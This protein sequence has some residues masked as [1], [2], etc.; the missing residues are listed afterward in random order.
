MDFELVD[1]VT[2][3]VRAL[4]NHNYAEFSVMCQ[5]IYCDKFKDCDL[6]PTREIDACVF[7]TDDLVALQSLVSIFPGYVDRKFNAGATHILLYALEHHAN[8]CC[9]WL[10]TLPWELTHEFKPILIRL[11]VEAVHRENIGSVKFLLELGTNIY[12]T[13]YLDEVSV[14]DHVMYASTQIQETMI[15]WI[16]YQ[17]CFEFFLHRFMPTTI[18]ALIEEYVFQRAYTPWLWEHEEVIP[19]HHNNKRLLPIISPNECYWHL[20]CVYGRQG[21][22]NRVGAEIRALLNL[23]PTTNLGLISDASADYTQWWEW[24]K[25][26]MDK[27][28]KMEKII[29]RK[30]RETLLRVIS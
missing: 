13:D 25:T 23:S 20:I 26:H 1:L 18:N 15:D 29:E 11:C 12:R 3:A 22:E 14:F 27:V 9:D 16:V 6:S 28:A 8:K 4:N 10:I 24:A 21:A 30:I 19:L 7:L 2:Q 17:F 5:R